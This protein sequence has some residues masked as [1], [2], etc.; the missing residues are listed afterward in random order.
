MIVESSTDEKGLG[1][2][3]QICTTF[4]GETRKYYQI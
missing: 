3:A 1:F 2:G 4:S